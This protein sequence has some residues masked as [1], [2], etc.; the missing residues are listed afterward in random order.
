MTERL[1]SLKKY[2]LNTKCVLCGK[3]CGTHQA[4]TGACPF[5]AR[6]RANTYSFSSTQFFSPKMPRVS[7]QIREAAVSLH[8]AAIKQ[9]WAG[10]STNRNKLSNEEQ[11][12]E[13]LQLSQDLDFAY[14]QLFKKLSENSHDKPTR[15]KRPLVV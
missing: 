4:T 11:K 8:A 2:P 15:R 12:R 14:W 10:N 13:S 7:K 3:T 1:A 5:G 6:A 9:A